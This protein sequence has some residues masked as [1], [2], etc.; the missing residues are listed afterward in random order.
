MLRGNHEC[1][2]LT[3]YFTFKIECQHKYSE[4]VYEAALESFCA[5]P[6]S[7]LMNKQFLCIHGG[8]SPEMRTLDDLRKVPYLA[9][10]YRSA[11]ILCRLIASASL[12]RA[13]S[14]ATSSGLIPW[15]TLARRKTRICLFRTTSAAAPTSTGLFDYIHLFKRLNV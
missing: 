15:R 10:F 9:V 14:C 6:L 13:A 3:E 8:I 1:R 11:D 5:L 12:P 2:H 7:A 4:K